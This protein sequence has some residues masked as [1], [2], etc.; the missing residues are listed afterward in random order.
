MQMGNEPIRFHA[1]F[2]IVENEPTI[3]HTHIWDSNM[4]EKAVALKKLSYGL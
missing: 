3:F 1:L 4:R 2:P